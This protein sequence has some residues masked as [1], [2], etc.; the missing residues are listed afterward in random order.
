MYTLHLH[1]VLPFCPP[2]PYSH[3]I[4]GEAVNPLTIQ[5][6]TFKMVILCSVCVMFCRNVTCCRTRIAYFTFPPPPP[7]PLAA[8]AVTT[9]AAAINLQHT[10]THTQQNVIRC[11]K[12]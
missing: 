7:P 9:A 1:S 6:A 4:Q 12:L 3:N 5:N 11:S 2:V 8:A 10:Q